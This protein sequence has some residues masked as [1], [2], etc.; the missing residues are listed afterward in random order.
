MVTYLVFSVQQNGTWNEVVSNEQWK[1][2][3]V[4]ASREKKKERYLGISTCGKPRN[5]IY[6]VQPRS[7]SESYLRVLKPPDI[8]LLDCSTSLKAR[9]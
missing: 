8:L 1:V 9:H 7:S 6:F 3:G 4:I 2:F 5:Y